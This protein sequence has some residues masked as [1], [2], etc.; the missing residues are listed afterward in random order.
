MRCRRLDLDCIGFGEKRFKF[1][2]ENTRFLPVTAKPQ[3]GEEVLVLT[4]KDSDPTPTRKSG[5]PRRIA[6]DGEAR[7]G[8]AVTREWTTSLAAVPSNS[9]TRIVNRFTSNL[10]SGQDSSYQLPWNFG[11]FLEDVPRHLGH[12]AALDSAAEALMTS[13]MAFRT[14]NR[15]NLSTNDAL[16]VKSYG[17]AIKS[18]RECLNDQRAS[19]S[20]T[21][22]STMILLIVEVSSACSG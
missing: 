21:L 17:K 18:L 11:P 19:S 2:D 16:C 8:W 13:Y 9:L 1:Q 3:G 10:D 7:P 22:C 14:R 5:K 6:V 12:N 4:S 20:E 15:V